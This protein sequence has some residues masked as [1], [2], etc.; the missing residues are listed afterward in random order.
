MYSIE[1][2]RCGREDNKASIRPINP[3]S[4]STA[5]EYGKAAANCLSTEIVG[6]YS[7]VFTARSRACA[8]T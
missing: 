6:A 1:G 3:P 7:L 5:T 8:A 4:G 2:D